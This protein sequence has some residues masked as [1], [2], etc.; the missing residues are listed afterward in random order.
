MLKFLCSRVFD[1]NKGTDE[2]P[3]YMV[4]KPGHHSQLTTT[5]ATSYDTIKTYYVRNMRHETSFL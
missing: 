2:V 4:R 1:L 5:R 3:E